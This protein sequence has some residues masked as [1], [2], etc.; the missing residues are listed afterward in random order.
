M[1]FPESKLR[2]KFEYRVDGRD[3]EVCE[4]AKKR[5]GTVFDEASA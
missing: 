2:I 1:E 4:R 3:L 5:K